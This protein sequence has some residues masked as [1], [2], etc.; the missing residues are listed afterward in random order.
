RA[1]SRA[2]GDP[3]VDRVLAGARRVGVFACGKAAAAMV[4]ALPGKLRREALVVLPRGYPAK[5][6]SS[7]EVLFASH[8]EP[9]ASSVAAARRAGGR[10]RARGVRPDRPPPAWGRRLSRRIEPDRPRSGGARGS[11]DGTDGPARPQKA[12]RRGILRGGAFRAGRR[13]AP[14]RRRVACRG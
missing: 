14:S 6:L 13:E 9:G 5:G 12:V 11:A 2:L 10:S 3:P 4:R 8:P 7:A 1:V